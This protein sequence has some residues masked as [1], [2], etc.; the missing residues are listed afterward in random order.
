MTDKMGFITNKTRIIIQKK[1]KKLCAAIFFG[2]CL[3]AVTLALAFIDPVLIIAKYLCR[4]AYGTY[5]HDALKSKYA[6]VHISAY[7]FN[8]TNAESFQSG[9]DQKLKVQEVGPFTYQEYRTNEN[10]EI[11]QNAGVIRYTP[12]QDVYFIPEE[13]VAN[14]EDVNLTMP[15]IAMLSF[16]SKLSDYSFIPRMGFNLLAAK[17]RSKAIVRM[18]AKDYLWGY[19]ES[20]IQL[21]NKLLPAFV[22]F[23]TLGILDRLYDKKAKFSFEVSA[24]NEDKFA[25]RTINKSGGLSMWGYDD[26]DRRDYCNSYT[27]V[28]EGIAYPTEMKPER[29]IR[30]YRSILCRFLQLD[31]HGRTTM[32]YGA[33]GLVYKISNNTY[34]YNNDTK[35]LCSKG[36]CLDGVSDMSPC[37]LGLPIVLSNSHFLYADPK[38]YERIDGMKPDEDLHG[39]SFTIEPKIG[40]VLTTSFSVQVNILVRDVN[41]NT[42][43]SHFSNMLV[44]IGFFKISIYA[45]VCQIYDSVCNVFFM[46]NFK[47]ILEFV[48]SSLYKLLAVPATLFTWN[49]LSKPSDFETFFIG[50]P[51]LTVLA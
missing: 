13:S 46:H 21:G 25:I 34:T 51:L 24:R 44:P 32:W 12:K 14:P 10:L 37:F 7:L 42:E 16:A 30:I 11:D 33:E 23:D 40:M 29:P 36:I 28:Y 1:K 20:L 2:L 49:L 39:S 22:N 38:L 47:K 43:T 50:A 35:C 27:N 5:V 48:A 15:N 9:E 8:I 41:F 31:Y 45:S 18:P 26:P 3:L 6:G 17:L 19:N 4:A